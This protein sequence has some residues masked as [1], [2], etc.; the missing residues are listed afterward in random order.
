MHPR[1]L[2]VVNLHAIHAD[3]ALA[4]S[5]I[6]RVHARQSDETPAVV[7][8]AFENRKIVEV[9]LLAPNHLLARRVLGAHGLGKSTGKRAE[10]RQHLQ[11]VE[12][13]FG[14]LHIH[15]AAD[16][17]RD[18][19]NTRNAKRKR[20]ALLRAKLIDENLVARVA[21]HVFEQQRRPAGRVFF[22]RRALRRASV[23]SNPAMRT[24]FRHA[25][26]DLGNFKLGRNFFA[27]ASELAMF[28]ER[29]DPIAQIVV[30]QGLAPRRQRPPSIFQL[31]A[32]SL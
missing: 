28:F 17:L 9:K 19:V 1:S 30:G 23:R 21:L 15:Q 3:V 16:A 29:L 4:R 14:S 8:P 20:H 12:Q 13:A 7:R 18:L 26:C 10:L 31:M 24:Y 32:F 11:L 25:V 6:A 27:D 5:R 2:A 22:F